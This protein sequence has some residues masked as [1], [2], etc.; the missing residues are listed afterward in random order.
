MA[1][2]PKSFA[3]GQATPEQS[4]PAAAP[5]PV[6]QQSRGFDPK[7]FAA[8]PPAQ[9]TGVGRSAPDV[10]APTAVDRAVDIVGGLNKG[11]LDTVDFPVNIY[12]AGVGLAGGS[13]KFKVEPFM[14]TLRPFVTGRP[15]SIQNADTPVQDFARTASEWGVGALQPQRLINRVPDLMA[16]FGAA[17]GEAVGGEN[18]EMIGGLVGGFSPMA[19]VGAGKLATAGT[20][21]LLNKPP[22]QD[23]DTEA[24][25][26]FLRG[27]VDE[28]ALNAA[29][30]D[31]TE[32]LA[33]GEAGSLSDLTRNADLAAL[34]Q[35]ASSSPQIRERLAQSY[36]ERGAQTAGRFDELAPT[37]NVNPAKRVSGRLSQARA[38]ANRLRDNRIGAAQSS[39]D[40]TMTQSRAAQQGA[41]A[42]AMAARQA[43]AD[44]DAGIGGTGRTDLSSTELAARYD[45]LEDYT[46][47]TDV[48]PAWKPINEAA[49]ISTTA[50]RQEISDLVEGLPA[51]QRADLNSK[52][53]GV[54]RNINNMDGIAEPREIQYMLSAVKQ[55]NRAAR[56]SGDFGTLN[57]DLSNISD[58][59]DDALRADVRIGKDFENAITATVNQKRQLGGE[60]VAKARRA[61][62]ETF[63][64]TLNFKGD[65][66]AATMRRIFDSESSLITDGAEAFLRDTFRKEG[67]TAKTLTEYA[68]ALER[69]PALRGQVENAVASSRTLDEVETA[70]KATIKGEATAQTKAGVALKES[71]TAA[72][73]AAEKAKGQVSGLALSKYAAKPKAFVDSALSAADDSGDL[74]RIYSRLKREGG[75]GAEAFKSQTLQSLKDDVLQADTITP[76]LQTKIDRL[77]ANDV[78][79]ASDVKEIS[80]I[81][82]QQEGRRL[83]RAGGRVNPPDAVSETMDDVTS[84]LLTLP[85]LSALPSGHQ[86]MAA[87]MFKR[88]FRKVLKGQRADPARVKRLQQILA[89]PEVFVQAMDGQLTAQTNPEQMEKLFERVFRRLAVAEGSQNEE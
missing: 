85:L 54:M 15:E 59:M 74:G 51:A 77:V 17:T 69:F 35:K 40:A 42:E 5:Q 18:G 31:T 2:D 56:T 55:V 67:V 33:R 49:P 3:A 89:T 66:G 53:S 38:Q 22:V 71:V 12:N 9:R 8:A 11:I 21:K 45:D 88:T 57:R 13:D 6:Q 7:A 24:V 50:M 64:S 27:N 61:D 26:R 4:A 86:L 70:T 36:G 65:K 79:G 47:R 16:G 43:A 75:G 78:I 1:F 73:S 19:A 68:P 48:Q 44:A 63:A 72:R 82:A 10:G 46:R 83:R 32:A 30:V 84:T 39:N 28:N 34:E 80:N 37:S 58:I 87:G 20:R 81:I 52:F 23:T 60:A 25:L 76:A 29:K 14:S 62:P 41:E